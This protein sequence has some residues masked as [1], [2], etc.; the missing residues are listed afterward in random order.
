VPRTP[1]G[2]ALRFTE[3]RDGTPQQSTSIK[4]LYNHHG[5][6][7]DIKTFRPKGVFERKALIG[8][9]HE[10]KGLWRCPY[11]SFRN[12]LLMPIERHIR[13]HHAFPDLTYYEPVNIKE[14]LP[15][16][17]PVKAE[18]VKTE[19]VKVKDEPL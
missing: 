3:A 9:P 19:P 14:P 11:C 12:H 1:C 4:H 17:D 7:A 8:H 6:N 2:S 10:S 16:F 15:L 13:I 18:P 5:L